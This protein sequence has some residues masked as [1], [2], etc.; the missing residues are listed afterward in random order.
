MWPTS[1]KLNVC[2]LQKVHY[3]NQNNGVNAVTLCY[4]IDWAWHISHG[5]VGCKPWLFPSHPVLCT[6]TIHYHQ[7]I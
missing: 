3:T 4:V 5:G 6:C 2:W 1:S 7:F